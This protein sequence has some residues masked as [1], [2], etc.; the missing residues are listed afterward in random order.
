MDI[1]S[2]KITIIIIIVANV[3][4]K[5]KVGQALKWVDQRGNER[6]QT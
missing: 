5:S 6:S 4:L 3:K 1:A 2:W